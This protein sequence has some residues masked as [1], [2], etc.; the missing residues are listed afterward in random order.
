MAAD[1]VPVQAGNAEPAFTRVVRA[2]TQPGGKDINWR[3]VRAVGVI[4]GAVAV[5]HGAKTRTWRV[6]H[7]AAT[8]LAVGGAIAAFLKNK[9][10]ST[11]GAPENK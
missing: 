10:V 11:P 3:W 9:F 7:S 8:A 2:V 4:V 5:A 1:E 6:V